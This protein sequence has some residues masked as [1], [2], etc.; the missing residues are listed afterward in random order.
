MK[1]QMYLFLLILS[2]VLISCG[3]ANRGSGSSGDYAAMLERVQDL[4]FQIENQ[5]A[6]PV[7]Y[8]RVNLM[9]NPNYIIFKQDSVDLFLPF[10]GERQFGGGYGSQGAIEY[11]GPL[12]DLRIEERQDKERINVYFQGKKDS[13][14]LDF[15]I[16]VFPNGNTSTTVTSSQR[17]QISYLGKVK[18]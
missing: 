12:R 18:K 2:V 5:W 17:D 10:F 15:Q 11:E 1:K 14:I 7:K 13:E 6:N 16:T 8:N 3:S 4:E 9:G